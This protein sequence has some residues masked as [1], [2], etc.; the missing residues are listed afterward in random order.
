MT[1]MELVIGL[2]ITGLMATAGARAFTSIVD[3]RATV[4]EANAATERAAAMREMIRS[5]AL[6]GTIRLTMGGVPRGLNTGVSRAGS[7]VT[8][9]GLVRG[10]NVIDLTPA[11][12]VGDDITI[13]TSAENPAMLSNVAI[14]LYIDVDENTPEKGL[15][16]EY[17]PNA[18]SSLVR[19]MLDSTITGLVVEYLDGRTNRWI[20]AAQGATITSFSGTRISFVPADSNASRL[21]TLPI[22]LPPGAASVVGRD[23][24]VG[25]TR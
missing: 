9:V 6:N 13:V 19:R 24:Q 7:G 5:W 16:I 23:V 22:T 3:H 8:S 1:L 17:Q 10:N 25:Q 14:R 11:K 15:T 2:A 18:R 20:S 12:H 21:L 4:R